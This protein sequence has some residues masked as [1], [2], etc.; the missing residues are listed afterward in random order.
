MRAPA[1]TNDGMGSLL[2]ACAAQERGIVIKSVMTSNS[3]FVT[4]RFHGQPPVVLEKRLLR[5]KLFSI[6]S[7]V[8]WSN[9]I[10]WRERA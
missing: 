5:G 9:E 10:G 8:G 4:A 3:D 7:D 6:R 2:T 1:P